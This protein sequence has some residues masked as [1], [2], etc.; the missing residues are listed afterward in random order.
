MADALTDP[1]ALLQRMLVKTLPK[2]DLAI[3]RRAAV[4]RYVTPDLARTVTEK[5]EEAKRLVQ[6][7]LLREVKTVG[8]QIVRE[9]PLSLRQALLAGWQDEAAQIW[10]K[11][12]EV[13]PGKEEGRSDEGL[14]AQLAIAGAKKDAL[15]NLRAQFEKALNAP[16]PNVSRAHDLLRLLDE[17]PI[18]QNRDAIALRIELLPRLQMFGRAARDR[19]ATC[20][21]LVRAFEERA[22]ELLLKD[23]PQWMLQIHA[24]GGRGKTMFLRNLLGRTCPKENVPAARIDFDHVAH[25]SVVTNEPWRILLAIARQLNP[26]LQ[27]TPFETILLSYGR[28]QAQLFSE[29]HPRRRSTGAIDEGYTKDY[30]AKSAELE[31]PKKFRTQLAEVAGDG[32]VVVVLDTAETVLHAEGA[33][34]EP[35]LRI[36]SELHSG[37]EGDGEDSPRVPGLRVILCGRFD[38]EGTRPL[39]EG[40]KRPRLEG[41]NET[42]VGPESEVRI[43]TGDPTKEK[44]YDTTL[45][46]GREVVSLELPAF[47]PD[48][49]R[50]YLETMWDLGDRPEMIEII[51]DR[52]KGNPMKI[53][54]VAEHV[55]KNPELKV[56]DVA[57]FESVELFY[58]VDRVVD[59]IDDEDGTIQWLL[60]WGVLPRILTRAFVDA[61][62]WPALV[63]FVEVQH[64]Y[65]DPDKDKLPESRHGF[66]R[67]K[68]P[69]LETVRDARAAGRAWDGLLDYA[70]SASWVSVTEDLID[71]VVF[72]PEVR[73]PLRRLLRER[74]H[75][76]YDD[77]HRKAFQV[78]PA[79]KRNGEGRCARRSPERLG[80]PCLSTLE[81]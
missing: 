6:H 69:N 12:A 72:H 50:R 16:E 37:A 47:S 29:V 21:Y 48:E 33:D 56:K 8:S 80:I 43:E 61:V 62:V 67:W 27:H 75:P 24:P 64:S 51:A 45:R 58:L 19:E 63:E 78:L 70:A 3:L 14:Y 18:N 32:T 5:D 71:A 76:A 23:S 59:R 49:T 10:K 4:L 66:G 52:C 9:M 74:R 13:I 28:F 11:V 65:D 30:D 57:A 17:W 36:L 54:L 40:G 42:W 79:A 20:K 53:A 2:D 77:I 1:N 22:L 73:G 46:F 44:K 7:P 38:L 31:V 68:T 25:L 41:F 39:A 81:W 55:K 60:R 26:Q 35:L 15:V 34:L